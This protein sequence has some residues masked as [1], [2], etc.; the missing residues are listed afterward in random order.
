M[1]ERILTD[2]EKEILGAY[3]E[4]GKKIEAG[5]RMLRSRIKKNLPS[6]NAELDLMQRVAEKWQ[7][8]KK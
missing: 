4:E 2:R 8:E 6:L 3:L 1:R 5:F 7:K